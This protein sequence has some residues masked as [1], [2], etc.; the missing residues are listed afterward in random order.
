MSQAR[1][2]SS[3]CL[4]PAMTVLLRQIQ[5]QPVEVVSAS[6]DPFPYFQ[7]ETTGALTVTETGVVCGKGDGTGY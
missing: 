6:P 7:L 3:Q 5:L 4:P 2:H 1:S